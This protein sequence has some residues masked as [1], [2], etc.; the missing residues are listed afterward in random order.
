MGQLRSLHVAGSIPGIQIPYVRRDLIFIK[1]KKD[2]FGKIGRKRELHKEYDQMMREELE[3][4]NEEGQ[5]EENQ[6]QHTPGTEA[7]YE[8]M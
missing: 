1:E 7:K 6:N 8:E 4:E 2:E 3:N 5:S